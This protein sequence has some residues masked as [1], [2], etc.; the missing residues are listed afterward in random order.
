MP[1]A[2]GCDGVIAA[3]DGASLED[4]SKALVG[5][6]EVA[7]PWGRPALLAVLALSAL[8]YLWDLGRTGWGY[9]IYATAVQAGTRSW[10]AALFGSMDA[11]N[12]IS[13]D[14]S[15]GPLWVM[16]ASARVFG[17]SSWSILVPEALEGVA[18]VGLV[19]LCVK[20]WSDAQAGLV[21]ASLMALTPAA[22]AIFRFD[23]PDALLTLCMV[24]SAYATV[25]AVDDGRARWAV[26]AGTMFGAAFLAK[27]LEA[28][29]VG[30]GLLVAYLLAGP[31][32]IG[33]R[34]RHSSYAGGAALVA[35]GWWPALVELTPASARP[36][37]G[38]TRDNSVLSLIFGYD[39]FGR[40]SG[41]GEAPPALTRGLAELW[42][43]ASRIFEAYMGSQASWF[44]LGAAVLGVAALAVGGRAGRTDR[45]RAAVV[46]WGGWLAVGWVVLSFSQG[47]VHP[48]YTVVLAPP[49]AALVGVGGRRLWQLRHRKE[50][51]WAMGA[52]VVGTSLWASGVLDVR[53][54]W[55]WLCYAVLGAGLLAGVGALLWPSSGGLGR[56]GTA[57]LAVFGCLAGPVLYV[58]GEIV[59]PPVLADPYAAPPGASP[60][61]TGGLVGGGMSSLSRPGGTLTKELETGAASYRWV[62]ATVGDLPA[63]GYQLATGDPAMAIGGWTGTDPAPSLA[64][65]KEMVARHQVHYFIPAG[66]YGGIVLG[67]SQAGS[68][69]CQ[70]SGWVEHNFSARRVSGVVVYDLSARRDPQPRAAL[71]GCVA[72]HNK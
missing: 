67:A 24:G 56:A 54:S 51:R 19:Y 21:A 18:T 7:P 40:I 60:A 35:G 52:A 23:N 25:R 58:A 53:G 20:R 43:D 62:V 31:R 61:V 37:V 50:A 34:A 38:G 45:T 66:T 32:G 44:L 69:A 9:G 41:R 13:V 48:Y 71:T 36:Y 57:L 4:S 39:G 12:F 27:L 15:P 70:V 2:S 14:K 29:V 1:S 68:D 65:F 42:A 10:K 59:N 46:L 49:V 17:L 8:A 30:P 55:G 72:P 22:A 6:R 47:M 5:I 63:G 11:G 26:L 64:E 16:E 28:L 33:R 3:P